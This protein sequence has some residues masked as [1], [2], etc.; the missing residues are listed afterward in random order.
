MVHFPSIKIPNKSLAIFSL[1]LLFFTVFSCSEETSVKD[2]MESNHQPSIEYIVA[3]GE[4]IKREITV[5]GTIIP[6]EHVEIYSEVSGRL[7][8]INFKEGE[9][10]KK[11]QVLIE[12]DTDINKAELNQLNVELAFAKKEEER[13]KKLHE[14]QAGTFEEFEQAQS[15]V[16]TLEARINLLNVQIDKGLIRAPFTGYIGLRQVSEGAY[17]T[18]STLITT[19]AQHDKVKIDFSVAQRYANLVEKGQEIDVSYSGDDKI[20]S[21]EI[22]AFEP[23][24]Q[25]GTRMLNIRA[26]MATENRIMP[27]SFVQIKYNLGKVEGAILIPTAALVPVLNGQQIWLKKN[28]KA[29]PIMVEPGIRYNDR[30]QVIGDIQEGDTV[31]TTGLLGMREGKPLTGKVN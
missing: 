20:R 18:P 19:L 13:K 14:N 16:K 4:N 29:K 27:G 2:K 23:T 10:V 11:G 8:K 17:I 6:F 1:L 21:A 5:P 25:A 7:I 26:V 31:I 24:V 28:G 9:E 30:V 15:R 12:V 22:Y 3:E